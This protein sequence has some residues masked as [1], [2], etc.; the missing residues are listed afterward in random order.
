V[1]GITGN[2]EDETCKL[3]EGYYK[4]VWL[5]GGIPVIIPPL[6]DTDAIINTLEHIDGLLLSGGADL[7][8]LYVGEEPSPRLGG[9]NAERDLPELLITRLAYNRQIPILGICRG[10]QTLTVALGGKVHQDISDIA[11]IQHS[12][13]AR[14]S[15]PTHS[16]TLAPDSILYNIYNPSSQLSTLNSQLSTVNCQLSTLNCPVP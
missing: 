4:S 5:A 15:E 3:G 6:T 13:D 9:I 14:R 10:I 11:K 7:N 1:I 16:V 2:Y 8:P 12:Q